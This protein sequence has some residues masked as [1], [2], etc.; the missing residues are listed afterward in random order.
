MF[1]VM[2]VGAGEEEINAVKAQ[3]LAEGLHPHESPGTDRVVIAV[4]GDVG[5]R[6][7]NSLADAASASEE[8]VTDAGIGSGIVSESAE[9]DHLPTSSKAGGRRQTW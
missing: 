8:G 5:P 1:V 6:K 7:I 4:V 9:R 2:A 3:V